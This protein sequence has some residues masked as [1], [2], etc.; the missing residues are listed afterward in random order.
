MLT[1]GVH[2]YRVCRMKTVVL[3]FPA[4]IVCIAYKS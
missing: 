1:L 3:H 4:P 2:G